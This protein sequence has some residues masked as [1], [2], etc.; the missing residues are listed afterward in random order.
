MRVTYL[1]CRRSFHGPLLAPSSRPP[2]PH[3]VFLPTMV[4]PNAP[5]RPACAY[6]LSIPPQRPPQAALELLA[7]TAPTKTETASSRPL[8]ASPSVHVRMD[9]ATAPRSKDPQAKARLLIDAERLADVLGGG[10]WLAVRVDDADVGSVEVEE[11]N[12][13]CTQ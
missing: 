2:R 7:N 4:E 6:T 10:P 11:G 12:Y 8:R 1:Q 5:L 13:A 3:A 9:L